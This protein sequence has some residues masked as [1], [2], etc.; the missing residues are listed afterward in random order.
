MTISGEDLVR[1]IWVTESTTYL[2][3][4]CRVGSA[5]PSLTEYT[6]KQ[7]VVFV[8]GLGRSVASHAAVEYCTASSPPDSSEIPESRS[9]M[10]GAVSS[11]VVL[12]RLV[13][14]S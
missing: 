1:S 14:W 5:S 7:R 13:R 9:L 12:R 2:L 11:P 3:N 4:H 10:N 6:G 8:S